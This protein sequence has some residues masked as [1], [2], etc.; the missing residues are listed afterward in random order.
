MV[1]PSNYNTNTFLIDLFVDDAGAINDGNA[2]L[3]NLFCSDILYIH[4]LVSIYSRKAQKCSAA[5][6]ILFKIAYDL[7]LKETQICMNIIQL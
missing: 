1:A 3:V 6:E 2:T 4:F 7:N 5:V